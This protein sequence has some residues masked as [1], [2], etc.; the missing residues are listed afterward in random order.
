MQE[1]THTVGLLESHL[2]SQPNDNGRERQLQVEQN[3]FEA[4]DNVESLLCP[5]L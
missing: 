2:G 4:Q 5:N 1:L 3:Y